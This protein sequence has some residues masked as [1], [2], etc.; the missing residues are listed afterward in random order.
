MADYFLNYLEI[1]LM[2]FA[3]NAVP[4]LAPPT[5]L[6]L[7]LY[8]MG[9]P[10]LETPFVALAGVAGSVGG[11]LIMY[12][13]SRVFGKYIPNR[14]AENLKTFRSFIEERKW[15]LFF[16]TVLYSLSPL[17]SNFLFIASGI[18]R[19]DLL[20]MLGGFALARM[21][22]YVILIYTSMGVFSVLTMFGGPYV[23]DVVNVLGV[24]AGVSVIFIDWKKLRPAKTECGQ[25]GQV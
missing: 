17:P 24:I 8:H 14:Y 5:W 16:G 7:T 25:I 21:I 3:V 1:I 23:K 15:G 4:A 20:P 6:V 22:S 18:A 2:S 13:Y 12:C 9:H 10:F 19:T 11:R